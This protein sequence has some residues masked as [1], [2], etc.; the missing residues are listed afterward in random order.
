MI[1]VVGATVAVG[2]LGLAER[3]GV[4]VLGPLPAGPAFLRDPVD[5]SADFAA[6]LSGGLAVALVSFAD[7][8]V[9]SR[10]YA[11]RR[12]PMS[13][14]TRKWS[15]LERQILRLVFFRASQSAAA[16]R[17]RPLLR[18]PAKTQMTGVVG[19]LAVALLLI[20]A[21]NL[22]QRLPNSTLAAIVIT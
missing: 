5:R 8:S 18:P 12:E 15:G 11:A 4:S 19:A 3:A 21:P 10:S 16:R 2:V 1:A 13:T 14:P 17:A 7:T 22:L 20:A 9:L 6:V